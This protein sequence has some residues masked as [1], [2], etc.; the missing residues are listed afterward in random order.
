MAYI[1]VE[2]KG[3]MTVEGYICLTLILWR[4][5]I[6]LLPPLLHRLK[7]FLRLSIFHC[8]LESSPTKTFLC[9]INFPYVFCDLTELNDLFQILI[10]L[11]NFSM[12]WVVFIALIL[13]SVLKCVPQYIMQTYG[14]NLLI[15]AKLKQRLVE[16]SCAF[17][18]NPPQKDQTPF[19]SILH[20]LS[21][22]SS[23]ITLDEHIDFTLDG[24][25][26]Y[27]HPV[28]TVVIPGLLIISLQ[29]HHCFK[30]LTFGSVKV[31]Y[32]SCPEVLL[33]L[34]NVLLVTS[35]T[36]YLLTVYQFSKDNLCYFE[37]YS[38]YCL[39]KCQGS[40]Q[41]LLRGTLTS[42]GLYAFYDIRL[43]NLAKF[44]SPTRRK[45]T[46]FLIIK[47]RIKGRRR[48]ENKDNQK[49]NQK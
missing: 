28:I 12:P 27:F 37:C 33:S 42:D 6:S 19:L 17:N 44:F 14:L 4:K 7:L 49:G 34:N 29:I 26:E 16:D 36:K 9:G 35:I 3:A 46:E 1:I 10:H 23:P 8:H 41:I 32:S 25:I 11:L 20:E 22:I 5:V 47:E 43:L 40:D 45:E 39:V 30:N 21:S 18:S 48:G 31:F 38:N 2:R 24:L 15:T 13:P